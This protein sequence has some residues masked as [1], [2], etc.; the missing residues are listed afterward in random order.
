[1]DDGPV[2][3]PEFFERNFDSEDPKAHKEQ[4]AN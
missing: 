1:M 2:V 4:A 3:N